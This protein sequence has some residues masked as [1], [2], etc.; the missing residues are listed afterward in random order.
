MSAPDSRSHSSSRLPSLALVAIVA[1]GF[2]ARVYVM[3][4][5]EPASGDGMLRALMAEWWIQGMREHDTTYEYAYAGWEYMRLRLTGPW[6]PAHTVLVGLLV[7]IFGD[8]VFSGRLL[9]LVLGVLSIWVLYH[10]A[11]KT[12]G[13]PIGLLSAATL[14]ILPIHIT[15]STNPLTEVPAMFFLLAIIV[16]TLKSMEVGFSASLVLALA[17]LTFVGSMLRYELWLVIPTISLACWFSQRSLG[18]SVWVSFLMFLG[19][20]LWM[21]SAWIHHGNPFASFSLALPESERLTIVPAFAFMVEKMSSEIGYF[22]VVASYLGFGLIVLDIFSKNDPHRKILYLTT[23][24][25]QI[26]FLMWF[27]SR[28]GA[29]LWDRY[30][31]NSSVLIIPLSF[32]AFAIGKSLAKHYLVG[33]TI[34]CSIFLSLY[35]DRGGLYIR[36]RVPASIYEVS[37]WLTERL[38]P[39][40]T[41]VS[42]RLGGDAPTIDLLTDHRPYNVVQR[43]H[44]AAD[45]QR[46]WTAMRP[47]YVVVQSGEEPGDRLLDQ[48][49][50]QIDLTEPL[51]RIDDISIYRV[52]RDDGH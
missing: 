37:A 23:V 22:V 5:F 52:K 30:V 10:V 6:P 13:T 1:V 34:I 29:S 38:G 33:A 16:L 11:A 46:I 12:F 15:L 39:E 14:S 51:W 48:F 50:G 32:Y 27:S 17:I 21:L 36:S 31:F 49:A 4:R 35:I 41:F 18:R 28:R 20:I 24:F 25:M 9:S 43:H 2:A 47:S 42:T 19:P 26:A 3:A 45:L 8:A 7:P 44:A 40:D